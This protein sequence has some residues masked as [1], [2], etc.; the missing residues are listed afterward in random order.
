[1]RWDRPARRVARGGPSLSQAVMARRMSRGGRGAKSQLQD[2]SRHRNGCRNPF[3]LGRRP[4]R[5]VTHIVLFDRLSPWR[6]PHRSQAMRA[7]AP[8]VQPPASGRGQRMRLSAG[9]NR[10]RRGWT[11]LACSHCAAQA[12]RRRA[13]DPGAHVVPTGAADGGSYPFPAGALLA[14]LRSLRYAAGRSH[15]SSAAVPGDSTQRRSRMSLTRGSTLASGTPSATAISDGGLRRS[16]IL[17][18]CASC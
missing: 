3:P 16:S 9:S 18:I 10:G 2:R 12:P 13:R 5:L 15:G 11:D 1:M 6:K 14:G 8:A 7:L 17:R 4:R